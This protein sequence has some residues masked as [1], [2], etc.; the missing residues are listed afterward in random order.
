MIMILVLVE[1]LKPEENFKGAETPGET[2]M[3]INIIFGIF[4]Y[5]YNW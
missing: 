2:P 3:Q 4:Y 1:H 5:Q